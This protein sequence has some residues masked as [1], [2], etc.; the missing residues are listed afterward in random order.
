MR[1]LAAYGGVTDTDKIDALIQRSWDLER[2]ENV[3]GFVL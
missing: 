3:Y 2:E 1:S